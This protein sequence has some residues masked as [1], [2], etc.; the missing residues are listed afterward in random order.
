MES[1]LRKTVNRHAYICTTKDAITGVFPLIHSGEI[2]I[3]SF[4]TSHSYKLFKLDFFINS[5]KFLGTPL[6][7]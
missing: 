7:F 6:C 4:H 5:A 2:F 1:L 3:A